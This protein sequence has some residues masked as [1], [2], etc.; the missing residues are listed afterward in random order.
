L[1]SSWR[2]RLLEGPLSTSSS[3][4]DMVRGDVVNFGGGRRRAAAGAVNSAR[5]IRRLLAVRC[6]VM[7]EK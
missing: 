3:A 7:N 4:A 2:T 1:R 5:F 6:L